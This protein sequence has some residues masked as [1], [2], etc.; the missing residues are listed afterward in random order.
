MLDF[1][2]SHGILYQ[3]SCVDSPQQN[4]VVERKLQ[5][6]LQVV[7]ALLFQSNV[8][9]TFWSDCTLTTI[10]LINRIPSPI[11]DK[12][13]LLMNCSSKSHHNMTISKLLVAF[14]LHLY[15]MFTNKV[16]SS[17]TQVYISWIPS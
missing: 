8:P 10:H 3:R 1:Y 12:K 11:L 9:L 15:S 2:H 4:G 17:S 5:F 14:A 6:I 13:K 7:R 16:F